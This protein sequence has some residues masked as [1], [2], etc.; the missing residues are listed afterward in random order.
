MPWILETSAGRFIDSFTGRDEAETARKKCGIVGAK[1]RSGKV[2]LAHSLTKAAATRVPT[3]G[4]VRIGAVTADD[5]RNIDS[6]VLYLASK[7][8]S[9][10]TQDEFTTLAHHMHVVDVADLQK[11]LKKLGLTPVFKTLKL[12]HGRVITREPA[13][14]P[15][16]V[17]HVRGKPVAVSG[18]FKPLPVSPGQKAKMRTRTLPDIDLDD[19]LSKSKSKADKA[20]TAAAGLR[21]LHRKIVGTIDQYNAKAAEANEAIDQLENNL[22]ENIKEAITAYNE[23]VTAVSALLDQWIENG[24]E[25]AEKLAQ[26][27]DDE[28]RGTDEEKKAWKKE[29]EAYEAW[30]DQVREVNDDLG[31]YEEESL[32][33]PELPG[34]IDEIADNEFSEENADRIAK[35]PAEPGTDKTK[36]KRKAAEKQDI[37]Q[38]GGK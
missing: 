2:P 7:N 22:F 10:Y 6:F 38:L 12:S 17:E 11:K 30:L 34:A 23:G 21:I 26:K 25:H 20:Q 13:S 15:K 35:L 24:E 27:A 8:R 37:K 32:D 16:T 3:F 9:Q 28:T 14:P 33:E 36:S 29:A 5:F 18:S 19:L 4:A 1:V 31:G